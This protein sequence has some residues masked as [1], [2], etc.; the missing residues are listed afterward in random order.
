M[1]PDDALVTMDLDFDEGTAVADAALA[2]AEVEHQVRERV[3]MIQRPF[4]G[5]TSK[6]AALVASG[7]GADGLR[8]TIG[9]WMEERAL[10]QP[11]DHFRSRP[12]LGACGQNGR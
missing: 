3:P 11:P 2:L 10:F 5:F 1:S 4:I 7:R 6:A 8:A 12:G 9:I